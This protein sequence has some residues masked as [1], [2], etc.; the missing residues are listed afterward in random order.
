MTRQF[1][2][3]LQNRVGALAYLTRALAQRGV[4]IR[5]AACVGSGAVACALIVPDDPEATR[6]VLV[7]L[8]MSFTEG[9][10][11]FVDVEDRPGGLADVAERFAA[12]GVSIL[13]TTFVGQRPGVIEMA[14][15][16]DDERRARAALSIAQRS[17]AGARA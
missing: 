11:I 16:V 10:P 8:G 13:G 17:H 1:V 5:Q 9:E 14:F 2:V 12:A 3:Q 4:D 6:G 7:D 15:I